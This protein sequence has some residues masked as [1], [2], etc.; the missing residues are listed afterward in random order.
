MKYYK[1]NIFMKC[2]HCG[3][4]VER[5]IYENNYNICNE[6]GYYGNLNYAERIKMILDKHTF[7]ESH[8]QFDFSNPL[9]FP[10]YDEKYIKAKK[11]TGLNEAVITGEGTIGGHATMY[12][13]MDSGFM[14]GSMGAV[15]GEKITLLFE[16]AR[17]K[18]LPVVIFA[19]SGGARM[20]E[21]VISLMQMVKT[22]AAVALFGEE[23]GFYISILTDPTM[24]GV[25]ASFAFLGDIIIAEP[26]ALIGFAGRRVIKQTIKKD[27]PTNFQTAE[28]MMQHGF[29]DAIV[30][31]N[32]LKDR[33][34][35][36]LDIH[37]RERAM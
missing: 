37:D 9:Y 2:L 29:I 8:N 4:V 17:E 1:D 23:G 6:C 20:Q 13:I 35:Y 7:Q 21:G 27:L 12:A 3:S 11:A 28:Y 19:A 33:I 16:E 36:L 14:M 24:G 25:S 18:K 26:G 31:R 5:E 34:S 32:E 15:V 22:S 10:G 30:P